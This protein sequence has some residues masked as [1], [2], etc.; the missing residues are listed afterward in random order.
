M[1]E[2]EA[3][4]NAAKD[5]GLQIHEYNTTDKRKTV[6]KYFA[7][8]ENAHARSSPILDYVQLNHFLLGYRSALKTMQLI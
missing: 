2:L 1:T 8:E 3:L 6:K 7:V 5:L 4:Q